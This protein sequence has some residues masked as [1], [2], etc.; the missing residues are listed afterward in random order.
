[1]NEKLFSADVSNRQVCKGDCLSPAFRRAR[2]G[3][4]A[5][6]SQMEHLALHKCNAK[7]PVSALFSGHV[8]YPKSLQLF[9]NMAE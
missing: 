7:P 4:L 9:G 8:S 6:C 3:P 1:M 5:F 2:A